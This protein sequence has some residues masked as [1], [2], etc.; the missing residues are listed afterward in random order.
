MT[1][2]KIYICIQ[3]CSRLLHMSYIQNTIHKRYDTLW[4]MT[5]PY[6]S[7]YTLHQLILVNITLQ[8]ILGLVV[9]TWGNKVPHTLMWSFQC[10]ILLFL[11]VFDCHG[12]IIQTMSIR[13]CGDFPHAV[14]TTSHFSPVVVGLILYY[15]R[16]LLSY[17]PKGNTA[18]FTLTAITHFSDLDY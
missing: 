15:F 3:I 4:M 14:W 5:R 13:M 2:H 9:Q 10:R 8:L 16:I 12:S 11:S 1:A 6:T 18:L 7:C 17:S